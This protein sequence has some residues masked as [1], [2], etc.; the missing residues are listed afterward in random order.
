M[1]RERIDLLKTTYTHVLGEYTCSTSTSVVWEHLN[2]LREEIEEAN[3]ALL[4]EVAKE[5]DNHSP[6]LLL[7]GGLP[8]DE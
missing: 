2:E 1:I 3:F 5:N 8:T 4:K 6:P 7:R